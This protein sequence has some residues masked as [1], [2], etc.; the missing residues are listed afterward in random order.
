LPTN[1]QF[2]GLLLTAS[3]SFVFK[4][5]DIVSVFF[6]G[7]LQGYQAQNA[8]W[9]S[10]TLEGVGGGFVFNFA[11][12]VFKSERRWTISLAATQQFWQYS[13]PD[14]TVDPTTFRLQ[15]DTILSAVLG[16]PFDDR[17]LLTISG[18]RFNRAATLPNYVF[19]NN[20]VMVG[21]TWR[22]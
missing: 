9:Q 13:A 11:D 18:G 17:T 19:V 8:A 22:F 1:S 5:T 2:T 16:I 6:S 10:Y 3:T 20:D 4:L 12:P 14:P 7:S 21:L 15:S